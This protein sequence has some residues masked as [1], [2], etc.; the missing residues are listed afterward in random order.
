MIPATLLFVFCTADSRTAEHGYLRVILVILINVDNSHDQQ[1]VKKS[2]I[3]PFFSL[4]TYPPSS[5]RKVQKSKLRPHTVEIKTRRLPYLYLSYV[6]CLSLMS[7][8]RITI[9]Y[10][11]ADVVMKNADQKYSVILPQEFYSLCEMKERTIHA[12]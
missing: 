12:V 4:P 10:C 3:L 8:Y 9:G 7:Y 2:E 6:L 5:R 11:C 1:E